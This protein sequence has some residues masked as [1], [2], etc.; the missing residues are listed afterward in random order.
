MWLKA[1]PTLSPSILSFRNSFSLNLDEVW[2][3]WLASEPQGNS[4]LW[5]GKSD[6]IGSYCH[7]WIFLCVL[8][9]EL[10]VSHLYK[11]QFKSSSYF[12]RPNLR[13]KLFSRLCFYASNIVI[14]HLFHSNSE[15]SVSW[16]CLYFQTLAQIALNNI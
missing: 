12:F 15:I 10:R 11:K 6:S 9:L 3:L 8:G 13:K 5:H 2:L 4:H 7:A 14:F 1:C 16:K